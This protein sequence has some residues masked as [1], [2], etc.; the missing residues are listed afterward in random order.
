MSYCS[1]NTSE[2]R[3]EYGNINF[4]IKS[5]Q[6]LDLYYNGFLTIIDNNNPDL[7]N[8]GFELQLPYENLILNSEEGPINIS[9]NKESNILTASVVIGK[10]LKKLLEF[11]NEQDQ[12]F[13]DGLFGNESM[14]FF[15]NLYNKAVGLPLISSNQNNSS[16]PENL[17]ILKT[18]FNSI[19]FKG[20]GDLF[21][22]INA[23]CKYGGYTG[24]NY[25]AD[26]SVLP[27]NMTPGGSGN[28][29][30]GFFANDRPSGT[31]FAFIL[32]NGEPEELNKKAF[33]GVSLGSSDLIVK[34]KS[35]LTICIPEQSKGGKK[36]IKK[37]KPKSKLIKQSKTNKRNKRNISN[38]NNKSKKKNRKQ[39][40]NKIIIKTISKN[41]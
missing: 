25:F 1:Y 18:I 29:I 21:Q 26:N 19:L 31:R 41:K 23:V 35:N 22:E 38:N 3:K 12:S 16:Y 2:S 28:Q 34:L 32:N 15:G 20:V 30:R 40:N 24:D 10:T 6:D 13:I 36:T 27:Y 14:D 17:N 5:E 33:G 9:N 39:K 8:I 4:K 7:I 37:R 11:I